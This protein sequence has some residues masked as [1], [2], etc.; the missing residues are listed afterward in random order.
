MSKS[1]IIEGGQKGAD[2]LQ[3]LA[4]ATWKS[5]RTMLLKAGLKKDMSV[6]DV[7]CGSGIITEHIIEITGQNSHIVGIDFDEAKINIAL[8]NVSEKY[9]NINF[10]VSNVS[11][12]IEFN[13][14]KYDFIIAR[15]LFS[16]LTNSTEILK[17][18]KTKLNPNG[19]LYAEDVDFNGY[20]SYP[21]SN[22]FN[23]YVYYYKQL[24]LKVGADP[25]I[26]QKLYK[27]FL[28][29]DFKNVKVKSS[30]PVFKSGEGKL[31]APLTFEGI[32]GTIIDSGFETKENMDKYVD[33]LFQFYEQNDSIISLPRFFYVW[34]TN[35]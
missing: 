24:G 25:M 7:G 28:N 35:N 5:T 2:R 32:S 4:K 14:K 29:E 30:N 11:T 1:Y 21:E 31:V 26:G 23:K 33:E 12:D 34:G 27:M 17:E 19:I 8:K 9:S 22:A 18:L 20:F 13:K 3:I 16:H 10:Y 15:F 6:L